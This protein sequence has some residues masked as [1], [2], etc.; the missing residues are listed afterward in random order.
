MNIFDFYYFHYADAHS[1]QSILADSL[2]QQRCLQWI[3]SPDEEHKDFT[4]FLQV[5]VTTHLGE[6]IWNKMDTELK[7][8]VETHELPDFLVLPVVLYKSTLQ[9]KHRRG[10]KPKFKKRVI[11][12]DI[13]HLAVWITMQYGEQQRD[14][15]YH[16]VLSK[17]L[18]HSSLTVYVDRYIAET[19]V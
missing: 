17:E 4:E 6:K 13:E 15:S 12:R 5:A 3:T 16:F 14:G 1:Q 2:K 11:K 9:M 19:S 18:F 10:T 7:G 8:V